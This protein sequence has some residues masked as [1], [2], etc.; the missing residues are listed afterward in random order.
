MLAPLGGQCKPDGL[1][2]AKIYAASSLCDCSKTAKNSKHRP[3]AWL[4]A[5]LT[6]LMRAKAGGG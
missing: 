5:M 6:P 2:A 4:D 1:L 3:F